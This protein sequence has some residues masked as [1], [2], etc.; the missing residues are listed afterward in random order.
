MSIGD[1]YMATTY[2]IDMLMSIGGSATISRRQCGKRKMMLWYQ[3]GEGVVNSSA[4]L[5][6]IVLE[7]GCGRI[8]PI[9][10]EA[11]ARPCRLEIA[12]LIKLMAM[13]CACAS[14]G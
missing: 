7:A 9:A 5:K 14:I 2:V 1:K 11:A 10:P 6:E 8:M 12:P 13:A 3:S 4:V